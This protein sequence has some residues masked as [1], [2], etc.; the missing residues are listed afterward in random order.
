MDL[1]LSNLCQV[2]ECQRDR[3]VEKALDVLP[4]GLEATYIRILEQINGQGDYMRRLASKT[5]RWVIYAQRPLTT[6]ELQHAIVAEELYRHGSDLIQLF[7]VIASNLKPQ[8]ASFLI[9]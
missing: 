1:Q 9:G 8:S 5:F 3:E 7:F 6:T 4:S 2:S